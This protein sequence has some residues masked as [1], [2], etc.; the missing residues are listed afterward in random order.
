MTSQS[1]L[2]CVS[3]GTGF[4]TECMCCRVVQQREATELKKQEVKEDHDKIRVI[5]HQM[6]GERIKSLKSAIKANG[7]KVHVPTQP[8]TPSPGRHDGI[9]Y[10][11]PSASPKAYEGSWQSVTV[12]QF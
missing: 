4:S 8:W 6:A 7:G 1:V 9:K 10:N 11:S 2:H 5:Q 12:G 3:T